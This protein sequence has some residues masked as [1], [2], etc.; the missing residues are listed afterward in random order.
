MNNGRDTESVMMTTIMLQ[1]S[2]SLYRWHYIMVTYRSYN[3]VTF[4]PRF[5]VREPIKIYNFQVIMRYL[6]HG[7]NTA[8]FQ[9]FDADV[10]A[11]SSSE[12]PEYLLLGTEQDV[13]VGI[14]NSRVRSDVC[15]TRKSRELFLIPIHLY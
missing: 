2:P 1:S 5:R 8:V 13:F 7:V 3:C 4:Q 15:P 10:Y 11:S 12:L 14:P 6:Q 9:R